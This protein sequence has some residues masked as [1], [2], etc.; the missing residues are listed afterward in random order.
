MKDILL[1]CILLVTFQIAKAQK[2]LTYEVVSVATS[3]PP[4]PETYISKDGTKY[5]IGDTLKMGSPSGVNGTWVYVQGVTWMGDIVPVPTNAVNT[6]T[7]IK[8]L[9]VGGTKKQGFKVS[10]LTKGNGMGTNYSFFIEDAIASGEVVDPKAGSRMTSDKAL[11]A[12]KKEKDKLDL[13]LISQ[14]EYELRKAELT[15]FIK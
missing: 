2:E 8:K 5:T 4:S 9:Y 1:F 13:G 3:K 12:L 11:E 14:E 6:N 7:V 15:K 10:I